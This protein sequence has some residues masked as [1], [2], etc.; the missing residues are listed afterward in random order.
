MK[1]QGYTKDSELF[2]QR[3][4]EFRDHNAT[5]KVQHNNNYKRLGC[6]MMDD[7]SGMEDYAR[8]KK[9]REW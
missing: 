9:N 4:M 1:D 3:D 8:D 7:M 6:D 5:W 2:D